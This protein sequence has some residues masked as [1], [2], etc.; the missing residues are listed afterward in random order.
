M[1]FRR[2]GFTIIELILVIAILAVLTVVALLLVNPVQLAAQT[3]DARRASDI[4]VIDKALQYAANAGL[5]DGVAHRV[6]VSIPDTSATCDNLRPPILS[7]GLPD[8]ASGWSY[9]CASAANYRRIDGTGWIPVNFSL[10]PSLQIPALPIDPVNTVANGYYYTFTPGGSWALTSGFESAK[11]KNETAAKDNGADATRLEAGSDVRLWAQSTSGASSGSSGGPANTAPVAL[12]NQVTTAHGT[13]TG[14]TLTGTD[15]QQCELTF[16][17]LSQPQS[18]T[19]GTT[20]TNQAC[21]SGASNADVATISYTPASGFSGSV[22]FTYRVSDGAANSAAAT[23]T[24]T[25]SGNAAPTAANK[26]STTAYESAAAI[27]LT[28]TDPEQCSLT[29]AT[30]AQPAHGSLSSLTDQTCA[31]GSPK[32]DSALV[33]YTPTSGYSGSDS[34]TYRANDGFGNSNTATV[35]VT[36][37]ALVNNEPTAVDKSISVNYNTATTVTLTATDAGQCDL[38]FTVLSQ[39]SHGSVSATLTDQGCVSGSPNSDSATVIYTP[40][41]AYSGADSF[42]Y[43]V[44]DGT[45]TSETATVSLTVAAQGNTV[46]TAANKNLS[47]VYETADSITLTGT[48]VEQCDLTF[49][50]VSQQGHGTLGSLSNQS[51]V[52]GSPKSDSATVTYTPTSGYSGSDSFTYKTNDSTADSSTATVSITVS[53]PPSVENVPPTA[54]AK[55][56]SAAYQTAAVVTLTSTDSDNCSETFSVVASPLHGS[57]GSITNQACTGSPGSYADSATITY[58]PTAGYS[59]ADSFTYKVNDGTD[60]SNTATVSITVSAYVAPAPAVSSV[61]PIYIGQGAANQTITLT[62]SGFASGAAVTV[63]TNPYLTVHSTSFINSTTLTAN[64]SVAAFAWTGGLAVI[65]TNPDSQSG[66]CSNCLI[67]T[68]GPNPTGMSPSS[69]NQGASNQSVTV[70]GTDFVSGATISF[71]DAGITAASVSVPYSWQ[72]AMSLSISGSATAGAHTFTVVNPDGGTN[73]CYHCLTVAVVQGGGGGGGGGGSLTSPIAQW[74]FNE[75]S[76]STAADAIGSLDGALE[77]AAGWTTGVSGSAASFSNSGSD[78][79]VNSGFTNTI[80]GDNTNTVAFWFK[81]DNSGA[82]VL[83]DTPDQAGS[84]LVY[85]N[86]GNNGFYWYAGSADLWSGRYYVHTFSANQWYHVVLVKNGAGDSGDVY[87]DGQLQSVS[88]GY[89][90]SM[91]S[92]SSDLIFGG[93]NRGSALL[94]NGAMDDVRI[95]NYALTAEQVAALFSGQ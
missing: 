69:L 44:T 82:A 15:D 81:W 52:S 59:G 92:G 53:G 94:L 37:S 54:A 3:R 88:G 28:A 87:I 38:T 40:D 29:F 34:F 46:P 12:S 56:L 19:L 30:V 18:G 42:T 62:G 84:Y 67:V 86:S 51:C 14:I 16:V 5:P 83:I 75:G 2:S 95:Y 31:S 45:Y 22:S 58:T 4:N 10:L 7:P 77:G 60:N 33:T 11:F 74:L 85:I 91:S 90:G 8:L 36:I 48:D 89:I 32:S 63:Q 25:V 93:Y 72:M 21:I 20:P 80:S 78:I 66:S 24:I 9:I 68:A 6:Y 23:I 47:V 71:D 79:A 57:L 70:T 49:T 50:I 65:V 41:S 61:N 1:R 76:G 13:V 64:I 43:R 26:S 39:P 27:T 35:S 55:T 17:I 73:I